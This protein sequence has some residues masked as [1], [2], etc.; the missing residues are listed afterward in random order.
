[1]LIFFDFDEKLELV[2]KAC[3][4]YFAK[5]SPIYLQFISHIFPSWP[6]GAGL[7]G[8]SSNS[9]IKFR[10]EYWLSKNLYCKDQRIKKLFLTWCVIKLVLKILGAQSVISLIFFRS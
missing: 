8:P 9:G 5:T 7:Y 3:V 1:M 10:G 4:Q 6:P 2:S